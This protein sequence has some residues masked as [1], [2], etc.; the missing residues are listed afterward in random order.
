MLVLRQT[1]LFCL[2]LSVLYAYRYDATVVFR[3]H[4][5]SVLFIGIVLGQ[6]FALLKLL[7]PHCFPHIKK[8][9]F[10]T[11]IFMLVALALV[12]PEF[13]R[14]FEYRSSLRLQGVFS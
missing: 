12:H 2:C 5:L 4:D 13:P 6:A 11:L 7:W 3:N 1:F 9:V 8:W 10:V 14:R